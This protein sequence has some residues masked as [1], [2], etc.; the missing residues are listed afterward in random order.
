VV[1]L[2]EVSRQA[3]GSRIVTNAHLIN[4][5]R[6]PDLKPQ[7]GSD[8]YFV[9]AADPVTGLEKLLAMVRDRIPR[10]FGLWRCPSP[11]VASRPA[12]AGR[13]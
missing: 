8:F 5:G 2:T 13:S 6:M 12:A 3:A 1:R 7:Q 9:K 4:R 11:C 10:R